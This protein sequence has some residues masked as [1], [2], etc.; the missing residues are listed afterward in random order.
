MD[1]AKCTQTR[2]YTFGA[3]KLMDPSMIK[4]L[5]DDLYKIEPFIKQESSIKKSMQMESSIQTETDDVNVENDHEP[6]GR[7]GSQSVNAVLVVRFKIGDDSLSI[8]NK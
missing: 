6:L 2:G 4:M 1:G 5:T 7:K 8:N 3:I